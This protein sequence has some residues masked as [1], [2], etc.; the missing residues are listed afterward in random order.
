MFNLERTTQSFGL[1]GSVRRLGENALAILQNRLELMA[2]EFKEEK[3]RV[4]SLGIW[5]A[6]LMFLGFMAVVALMLTL[7]FIFWEQRVAVM[8]GFCA[9]F[10]VGAI[11]SFFI[12]RTKIKAPPFSE[13][14]AQLKKDREWLGRK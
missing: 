4:A 7:T 3:S 2:I 1:F 10:F 13:T 11:G 14:M 5:A 8:G 9:F 6:A 12:L